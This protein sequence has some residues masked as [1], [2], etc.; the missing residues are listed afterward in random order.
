MPAPSSPWAGRWGSISGMLR[1]GPGKGAGGT[2]Q[3][4]EYVPENPLIAPPPPLGLDPI[5][6]VMCLPVKLWVA[7]MS[8]GQLTGR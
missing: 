3:R 6:L 4:G 2:R 8:L 7:R 1:E 5:R